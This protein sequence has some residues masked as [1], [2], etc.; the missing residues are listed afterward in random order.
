MSTAVIRGRGRPRT[1]DEDEVLDALTSLF[2]RQG[3]EATSVAD[4]AAT[5]GLKRSSL[6]NAFGSKLELFSRI[7]DR[8]I[9]ARIELLET[10]A[11]EAGGGI[12]ALHAFLEFARSEMA[13]ELGCN[14][15][16]AVNTATEFG[17][18][19]DEFAALAQKYRDRMRERIRSMI[20]A[21]AEAGDLVPDEVDNH[22]DMLTVFMV[23]MM[24][25][26]RGGAHQD[27]IDRLIDAAHATI[28]SWRT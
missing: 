22:T 5:T 1:F 2:W 27:E 16:L 10:M 21:A 9:T 12:D 14:G 26:A 7:L 11:A 28:D 13:T 4:I 3:Y 20:Q 8:Y 25:T 24:V 17:G 6:Y 15:C 19:D 18:D 23:G